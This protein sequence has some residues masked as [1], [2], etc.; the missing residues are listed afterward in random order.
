MLER[1]RWRFEGVVLSVRA[2]GLAL[3]QVWLEAFPW[4]WGSWL[5][6]LARCER[7]GL[8]AEEAMRHFQLLN[9]AHEYLKTRC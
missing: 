3:E 9:N 2:L 4:G 5:E 6:S 8:T 1:E 7:T